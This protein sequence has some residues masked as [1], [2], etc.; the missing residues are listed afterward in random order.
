MAIVRIDGYPEA[1]YDREHWGT[2]NSQGPH[3][4]SS[5]GVHALLTVTHYL[6]SCHNHADPRCLSFRSQVATRELRSRHYVTM[7]NWTNKRSGLR[8]LIT[9][10]GPCGL[11][12]LVLL[13]PLRLTTEVYLARET[14]VVVLVS[15]ISTGIITVMAAAFLLCQELVRQLPVWSKSAVVQIAKLILQLRPSDDDQ[16][17]ADTDLVEVV[18]TKHPV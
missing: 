6:P 1:R 11:G 10:A 7:P 17:A 15:T 16:S 14:L 9:R 4:E 3:L 8:K 18:V 13:A 5:M 2:H 12:V